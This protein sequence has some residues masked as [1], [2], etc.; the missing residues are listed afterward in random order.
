MIAKISDTRAWNRMGPRYPRTQAESSFLFRYFG[1]IRVTRGGR[2]HT[3]AAVISQIAGPC[4]C[5][6]LPAAPCPGC[7]R[8]WACLSALSAARAAWLRAAWASL[9]HARRLATF[10]ASR[11]VGFLR[12]LR[13]PLCCLPRVRLS[14]AMPVLLPDCASSHSAASAAPALCCAGSGRA[15]VIAC[16]LRLARAVLHA[17]P[18][19]SHHRCWNPAPRAAATT[20]RRSR[21]CHSCHNDRRRRRRFCSRKARMGAAAAAAAAELKP[22]AVTVTKSQH[23]TGSCVRCVLCV[24]CCVCV[25]IVCVCCVCVCCVCVCVG[26]WVGGWVGARARVCVWHAVRRCSLSTPTV[27]APHLLRCCGSTRP[28]TPSSTQALN[29]LE[30][31]NLGNSLCHTPAREHGVKMRK[32]KGRWNGRGQRRGREW[33]AGNPGWEGTGREREGRRREGGEGG[34]GG[35]IRPPGPRQAVDVNRDDASSRIQTCSHR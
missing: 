4:T 15:R 5:A 23:S 7:P 31:R 1:G 10:V 2:H 17:L 32:G 8:R 26:A 14:S 21:L 35:D 24:L 33:R 6:C 12:G 27:F 28:H 9:P 25:C 22:A 20:A 13:P 30:G 34:G 3:A 29:H 18:I 11:C 16:P 19:C